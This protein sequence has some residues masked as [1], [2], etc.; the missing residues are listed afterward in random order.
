LRGFVRCLKLIES[1]DPPNYD[2]I[3]THFGIVKSMMDPTY[4]R[5]NENSKVIVVEG[6]IASGKSHLA[7]RLSSYFGMVHFPDPTEDDIYRINSDPPFD[8]RVHNA[9]LPDSAKYYTGEIYWN[10]LKALCC[11]FNTGLSIYSSFFRNCF[12]GG[13][14]QVWPHLVIYVK[15][16]KEQIR[17]H[18]KKRNIVRSSQST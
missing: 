2:Y 13:H 10:Y 18:L 7:A 4:T 17:E 9:L 12:F 3:G 8:L 6:N 11:L 14:V 5:L 1:G 15:A 16:P